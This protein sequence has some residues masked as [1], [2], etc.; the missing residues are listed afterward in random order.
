MA[1]EIKTIGSSGQISLGKQHAGRIVT[2][3]EIDAGIWLVKAARV[4]PE[5]EVWLLEPR[6]RDALDRAIDWAEKHPPKASGLRA[7]ERRI[8]KKR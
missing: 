8:R 2:V 7:T 3:E 4:I 6:V 1:V 5:S